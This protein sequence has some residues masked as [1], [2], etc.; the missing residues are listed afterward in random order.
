[1]SG[2]NIDVSPTPVL[3]KR[4]RGGVGRAAPEDACPAADAALIAVK[5]MTKIPPATR[6]RDCDDMIDKV[7]R[8]LIARRAAMAVD[9]TARAKASTERDRSKG[10]AG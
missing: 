4:G 6:A 1:L 8:R 9:V 3:S 5:A 7:E 10:W 2:A